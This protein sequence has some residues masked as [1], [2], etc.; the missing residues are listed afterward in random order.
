MGR[1]KRPAAWLENRSEGV[2]TERVFP[3]P[4]TDSWL[5]RES[6]LAWRKKAQDVGPQLAEYAKRHDDEGS[7]VEEGYRALKEAGLFKALVPQ[8]LGGGGA[9]L[10]DV[11]ACIAEL[12]TYC[13]ST[14]L[15]YSMHSHLVAT[16]VWK[17]KKGQ[18]GEALLKKVVEKD[19]VLVSTGAGD[20]LESNGEMTRVEGGY[21]YTSK[22]AFASGSPMGD[23]MIT[24]GRYDDPKEGPRVLHFPLAVKAEGVRLGDDWDTH[25]MRGTGSN[26]VHIDGA[27]IADEAVALNRPRGP[28]HPAFNVVATVALPVLMSAYVGIAEHAAALAVGSARKRREDPHV[29]TLAGELGTALFGVRSLWRSQVDNASEYDFTP[30]TER[31][32]RSAEAKTALADACIATVDKAMELGGGGAYFRGGTIERLMR[33]VRAAPYHPLQAKRQHT[34]S[35]RVA[36]GLEAVQA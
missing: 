21:R 11:C 14:A 15:A 34:F 5:N 13:G 29:Q 24:S 20:W 27:F 3:D 8:D 2:M 23:M 30:D 33:D 35:G 1:S 22:K 19:L 18:P 31:A 6:T 10:G 12:A 28:W 36:L 26:T 16:T 9:G 32:C 25:G 4:V 17:H 7:F